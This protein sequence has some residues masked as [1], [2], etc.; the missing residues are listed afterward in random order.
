MV[1]KEKI[2]SKEDV[3]GYRGGLKVDLDR[4]MESGRTLRDELS[5]YLVDII[6]TETRN[7]SEY[8]GKISDWQKLYSGK[9]EKKTW[10]F[11]GCANVKTPV[12]RAGVD[13][14][15]VRAA[16]NIFNKQKVWLVGAKKAGYEEIAKQIED[17]LDWFQL[18]VMKFREK[19]LPALLQSI[20]IGT[21]IGEIVYEEK[22]KPI[23]KY[24][25]PEEEKDKKV[26]K[27][28]LPGTKSKA[29]KSIRSVYTGPNFY[30]IPRE[31]WIQSSDSLNIQECAACGFKYELRPQQILT[32][33]RQDLFD[34]ESADK[35]MS[36]DGLGFI[37]PEAPADATKDN[38]AADE[39]KKI[40]IVARNKKARFWE[41]WVKYDVDEDGE[42][43]SV[44]ITINKETGIIVAAIYNPIFGNFR[45]FKK[46]VFYP[47]EYSMD[48]EG[49]CQI[50]ESIQNEMDTLHNQRLDR[51]T[52]INSPIIFVAQGS[53]LEGLAD[54]GLSPGKIYV[55]D[56]DPNV[57]FKEFNFSN[58]TVSSFQEED[59]LTA[60]GDRA[61]GV[62]PV[63]YGQSTAERPVAKETM[64]V[65]EE[66]NKKFKYGQD[67]I[68][69]AIQD[70]GY[71]LLEFLAQ[72]QPTFKYYVKD[73]MGI[74]QERTVD[75]P[76]ENIR[77][78][79]EVRLVTSSE[80]MNQLERRQ[81][82]LE[83]YQ[84]AGDYM[85]RMGSM[86]QVLTN[87]QVPSAMKEIIIQAND[88]GVKIL[89]KVVDDYPTVTDATQMVMDLRTATDV[90]KLILASPDKMAEMQQGAGGQ[91]PPG[92][93]IPPEGGMPPQGG[94]G[95][96]FGGI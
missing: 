60:M 95:G 26:V 74:E 68:R 90:N 96:E 3:R 21:G 76:T 40:Q 55:C 13:T 58:T 35:L 89:K 25:T 92:A 2:E 22:R 16:D 1:D 11:I 28:S 59:R 86:A 67:N 31:D 82:N 72:Y 83:L 29:V 53:G 57:A 50:L 65:I 88:I 9:R 30:P 44:V 56:V 85:T 23:Y 62:G 46:F 8:I 6:D 42:E 43:D 45:P 49:I 12:V 36:K 34:E 78:V 38:R 17:G 4:K 94:P 14:I 41:L 5:D 19:L 20:K 37:I 84:L 87:R 10:P 7:Q 33:V 63:F 81:T 71:D 79:L 93:G 18:N 69:A 80:M 54:K 64:A 70:L 77:D 73:K 52:Q 51:I 32:R 66:T 27:Y 47:V 61:I 24:A 48:G 39:G 91:Q 75:F 15:F